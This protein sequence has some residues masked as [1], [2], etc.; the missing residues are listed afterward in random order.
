MEISTQSSQFNKHLVCKQR[1][2][3]Y[4]PNHHW[5]QPTMTHP[6][7]YISLETARNREKNEIF[8]FLEPTFPPGKEIAWERMS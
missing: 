3:A 4:D 5:S 7:S 2:S 1:I 6:D 8:T